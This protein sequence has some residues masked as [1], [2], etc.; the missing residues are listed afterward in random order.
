MYGKRAARGSRS[1]P[2]PTWLNLAALGLYRD[3]RV[4]VYRKLD[5]FDRALVE[6]AH[7]SSKPVTLDLSFAL[8]CAERGHLGLLQW[9]RERGCPWDSRVCAKAA[10]SGHLEVLQWAHE[11]GCPVGEGALAAAAGAG[12]LAV[13]EWAH[14]QGCEWGAALC[15]A[16][17]RAGQLQALRWLRRAGCPWDSSLFAAAFLS[18]QWHVLQYAKECG[19]PWRAARHRENRRMPEDLRD[20]GRANGLL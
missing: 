6:Q 17:A 15:T 11:Q 5:W 20:W 7:L 10:W 3:V 9:A 13:L 14:E 12:Q 18:R 1:S 8:E 16:A 2:A 19:C 4:L